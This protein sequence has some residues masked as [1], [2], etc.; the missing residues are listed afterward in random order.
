M[1]AGDEGRERGAAVVYG[2]AAVDGRGRI[3]D[4]VVMTALGWSPGMRLSIGEDRGLILLAAD[5]RGVFNVTPQ[6]HVRLPVGVR[7][8]CALV[9][10]TGCCWWPTPGRGRWS[11][12]RRSP[13]T[14][15]CG[16]ATAHCSVVR[17]HDQVDYR[18]AGT[19]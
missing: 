8:W 4:R 15:W 12:F 1:V 14:T 10:G 6:G 3:A 9:A 17:R 2:I 7:R 13:L 18:A 16:G 19:G 5:E 11:S